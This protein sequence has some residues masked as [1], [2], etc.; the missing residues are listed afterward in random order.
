MWVHPLDRAVKKLSLDIKNNGKKEQYVEEL[1]KVFKS[2]PQSGCMGGPFEVLAQFVFE[3]YKD[4]F[5]DDKFY[6]INNIYNMYVAIYCERLKGWCNTIFDK[7]PA[8]DYLSYCDADWTIKIIDTKNKNV[9]AFVLDLSDRLYLVIDNLEEEQIYIRT[10]KS[11]H[12]PTSPTIALYRKVKFKLDY[13]NDV[14]IY[15]DCRDN[16]Y[17]LNYAYGD[18]SFMGNLPE[19]SVSYARQIQDILFYLEMSVMELNEEF[20]E[21]IE[22]DK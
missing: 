10:L 5:S 20:E 9:K 6:A 18:I 22:D 8:R 17:I 21:E 16:G 12:S 11:K 3:L 7:H 13:D 4:R 15:G 19:H 14:E 2:F 1:I